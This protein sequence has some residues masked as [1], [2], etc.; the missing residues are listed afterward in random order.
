MYFLNRGRFL[1]K[2]WIVELTQSHCSG[3]TDCTG[4][5]GGKSS[6]GSSAGGRIFASSSNAASAGGGRCERYACPRLAR[7]ICWTLIVDS[8][9]A[10]SYFSI[11]GVVLGDING[12]QEKRH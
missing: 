6:G 11:H 9:L 1:I 4:I 8:R 10:Q 3:V 5:D 12:D 2:P 7:A